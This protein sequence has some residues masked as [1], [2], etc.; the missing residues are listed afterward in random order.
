[1]AVGHP[2]CKASALKA[3][4]C[5]AQT[6]PLLV[7]RALCRGRAADSL[8]V[9]QQVWLSV[10]QV[11][12]APGVVAALHEHVGDFLAEVDLAVAGDGLVLHQLQV[13]WGQLQL[14]GA[15]RERELIT[16]LI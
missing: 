6:P 8:A 5:A 2:G 14:G 11:V 7:V 12:G 4:L 3:L 9:L 13:L 16:W 1:M 15:R 10:G